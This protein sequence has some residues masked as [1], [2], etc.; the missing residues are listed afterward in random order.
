MKNSP[1]MDRS[2]GIS[3]PKLFESWFGKGRNRSQRAFEIW[4]AIQIRRDGGAHDECDRQRSKADQH[5]NEQGFCDA[6]ASPRLI[7][8][9]RFYSQHERYLDC[10]ASYAAPY[11]VT[12]SL[13]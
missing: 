3:A 2:L 13:F 6:P 10:Y 7:Q 12:A 1:L 8:K 11:L 9:H 4:F 5:Q